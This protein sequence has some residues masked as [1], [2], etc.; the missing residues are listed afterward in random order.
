MNHGMMRKLFDAVMRPTVLYGCE[1]WCT[2]CIDNMLPELGSMAG[3]Q[4]DFFRHAFH[5]SKSVAAQTI[6]LETAEV[7]WMGSWWSQIL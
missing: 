5:R 7:P 4:L 1:V 2:I 6:Y 3:I